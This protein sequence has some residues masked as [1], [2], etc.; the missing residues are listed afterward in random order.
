[1]AGDQLR[2]L[3]TEYARE[4]LGPLIQSRVQGLV[5]RR[6][7]RYPAHVY[8]RTG[9]W[10][11]EALQ[12]VV[13]DVF[14]ELLDGHLATIFD[15]VR[16]V[17]GFDVS[18]RELTRDVLA[19]RKQRTLI[20]NLIDKAREAITES[21]FA[22]TG[23]GAAVRFS[24]PGLES[25]TDALSEEEIREAAQRVVVLPRIPMRTVERAPRVYRAETFS[26]LL[27]IVAQV[28]RR[29]VGLTDLRRI[30]ELALTDL[31]VSELQYIGDARTE[32]EDTGSAPIGDRLQS[33]DTAPGMADAMLDT[34]TAALASQVADA[35]IASFTE[36]QKAVVRLKF[37]G[38]ADGDI[39]TGLGMSRPTAA[40]RKEEAWK[41]FREHLE[42]LDDD[43][44]TAVIDCLLTRL[45]EDGP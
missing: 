18:V 20:D 7:G 31:A 26:T 9:T 17:A 44:T 24:L 23:E 16:T 34:E 36:E 28:A 41:L 38:T 25:R 42:E 10:D 40:K 1:M 39:A 22:T 30:F 37:A 19:N 13:Q 21:P 14:A 27:Q 6:A 3:T 12:D 32:N 2:D 4:G 5:K 15:Y 35:V 29:P 43:E 33:S 11:D 45:A 8:A